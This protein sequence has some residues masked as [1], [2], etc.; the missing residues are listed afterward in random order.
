MTKVV[1]SSAQANVFFGHETST[2]VKVVVKQYTMEKFKGIFR[3]IKVFTHL[4]ERK[5]SR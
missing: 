2:G 4:E 5:S 1:G 3:E